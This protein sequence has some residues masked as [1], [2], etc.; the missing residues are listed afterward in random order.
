MAAQNQTPSDESL[1]SIQINEDMR[2]QERTWTVQ[3]LGWWAMGLVLLAALAGLFATGPLSWAEFQDSG[4]QVR[5]EVGRFQRQM[6]PKPLNVHIAPGATAGNTVTL[7][8]NRALASA[9]GSE[10]IVPFP[11]HAK[12]TPEG[13]EY[14]FPTA[15]PGQAASVRFIFNTDELGRVRAEVGLP[16]REPARFTLVVYP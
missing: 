9:V 16:G 7:I 3:R 13:V 2:L 4:G 15:G 12:V 10:Q 8:M 1:S 6:A 5:V 11:Q 14:T